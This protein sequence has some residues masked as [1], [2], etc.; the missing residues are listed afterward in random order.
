MR[1]LYLFFIGCFLFISCKKEG[2]MSKKIEE[3]E[4]F[5]MYKTSEMA[6][7]MRQ[8]FIDNE[9]LKQ[10][11]IDGESLGHYSEYFNTIHTAVFTDESDN[12]SFFKEQAKAFIAAQKA[13]YITTEKRETIAT[14]NKSIDACLHCHS[15]K[16]GGPIPK[17][18]KLY[19]K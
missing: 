9:A 7:L 3:K 13:I 10:R 17:I 11:I 5:E 1:Y 12:D 14:F 2:N 16:C 6:A 15:V 8:M 19:I 18:K 4:P